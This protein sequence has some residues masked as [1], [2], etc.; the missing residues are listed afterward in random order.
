MTDSLK[1]VKGGRAGVP[2]VLKSDTFVGTVWGDPV[3]AETDGVMINSVSFNPGARTNWHSHERGQVLIVTSGQGQV[4]D[5][6]GN[7][8]VITTGDVVFIPPDLEHW[9]GATENSSMVHTAISL[10]KSDWLD[11]VSDADYSA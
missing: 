11:P 3:L 9:H 7:G 1:I 8:S 6:D 4:R 10:G 5:R 2:S